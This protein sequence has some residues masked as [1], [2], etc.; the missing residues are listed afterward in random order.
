MKFIT[1]PSNLVYVI[2]CSWIRMGKALTFPQLT[3]NV[4]VTTVSHHTLRG[5]SGLV[6]RK[7]PDLILLLTF[8]TTKW[9]YWRK[10]IGNYLC[11][12]QRVNVFYIYFVD[13]NRAYIIDEHIIQTLN[14]MLCMWWHRYTLVI[15]VFI[16]KMFLK[17]Q[18]VEFIFDKYS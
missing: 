7:Y 18:G 11:S 6:Y 15:E 14:Y 9:H 2:S 17:F 13:W 1:A 5:G 16:I 10:C 12:L 8:R 4:G 3:F